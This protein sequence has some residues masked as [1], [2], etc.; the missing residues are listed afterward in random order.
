[1]SDLITGSDAV[2]QVLRTALL[3]IAVVLA[4]ICI[5]DWAVRTR[6]INPFG[7]V[8]RFFRSTVDPFIAPVER[9]VV[10]AGGMPAS[11]PLWALAAVVVGGI[12]IVSIL[13][14]I[15]YEVVRAIY[16]SNQGSAGLFRVLVGWTFGILK[17]ALLVRVVSSWLPISPYSKWVSWSYRLSEPILVPLRRVVPTLGAFDITPIIAY[18]LLSL[19]QSFLLRLV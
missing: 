16:H 17:I 12:I 14:F 4:V 18:L 2:M 5:M 3:A 9:K 7:G 8:A 13:D 6:R 10:R 15:R 1:M 19:I 11:A